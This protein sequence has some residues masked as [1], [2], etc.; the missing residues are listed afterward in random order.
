[1]LREAGIP[2]AV[3]S[4]QRLRKDG[5]LRNVTVR[6]LFFDDEE[7]LRDDI[8][9]PNRFRWVFRSN[10]PIIFRPYHTPDDRPEAVE[11]KTLD[12]ISRIIYRAVKIFDAYAGAGRV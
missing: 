11:R 8:D 9:H 10:R 12:M 7:V 5:P 1:M 2:F 6:F 4:Y 3:E